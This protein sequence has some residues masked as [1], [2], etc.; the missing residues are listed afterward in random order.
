MRF[1]LIY[2]LLL[3]FLQAKTSYEIG[4]DLYKQKG[5]YSCHGHKAEGM[6]A[7][8]ALANRAKGY[9]TYKLKRLR[10]KIS[11][12]QQQEMMIAYA[13]DLSDEDID[14]LTTF[15]S[16]YVD[17]ESAERYDDSFRLEGDGGS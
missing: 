3:S 17:E 4:K 16:E 6:H 15:F 10:S 8:P 1:F 2:S 13:V 9:M 14:N 5:C 7:Y 12:N 11:D